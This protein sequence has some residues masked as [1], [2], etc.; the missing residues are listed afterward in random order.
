[1]NTIALYEHITDNERK[2]IKKPKKLDKDKKNRKNKIIVDLQYLVKALLTWVVGAS[3][4]LMPIFTNICMLPEMKNANLLCILEKL[5]LNKDVYLVITTLMISVVLE[6]VFNGKN[7]CLN[8]ALISIGIILI[9]YSVLLFSLL[10]NGNKIAIFS[11]HI[12]TVMFCI[13]TVCSLIGYFN[14][15]LKRRE[16]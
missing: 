12:A 4:S 2:K 11:G 9:V 5:L 1:M 8:Y 15:S 10:Q 6:L 13:C 14:M 16:E 3:V 7:N